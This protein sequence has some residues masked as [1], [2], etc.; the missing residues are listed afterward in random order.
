MKAA[1]CIAAALFCAASPA[2]ATSTILCRS[3]T[4]P[5]HGPALS[6]VVGHGAASG[7]FQAHFRHGEESFTTGAGTGAPAIVQSWIDD[8]QL[9]LEIADANA[10]A[11]VTRLDTRR[12][13][14]SSYAGILIHRGRTW[15]VRCG[16]ES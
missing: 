7:I 16:E 14:G 6:L 15:R 13:A 8:R 12:R 3:T 4:S 1:S 11:I 10:E 9:K 5:T 2:L